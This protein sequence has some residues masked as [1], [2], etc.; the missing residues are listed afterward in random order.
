MALFLT[1]RLDF[2]KI[3][4]YLIQQ[5]RKEYSAGVRLVAM[6]CASLV[7]GFGIP[8][9]LF[10]LSAVGADRWRFKS[11]PVLSVICLV[12]A[13]LGLLLAAWTGWVQFRYARGT[14]IPIMPTKK[15]LT[16]KPYS[17][18]RNPM[19]L[20][21]ILFYSG[22]AV[23]TA[24]FLAMLAVLLFTFLL[25]AYIKLIEEKEMLLRFGDEYARYQQST[26]FIIPRLSRGKREPKA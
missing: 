7:F 18:C 24:S 8:A 3:W 1:T 6:G 23:Y 22:I 12:V 19:G 5:G 16:D 11:S 21:A 10:W 13:T 15:L 4:H 25:M 14:P 20:G 26:P 2:L 9:F 17:F